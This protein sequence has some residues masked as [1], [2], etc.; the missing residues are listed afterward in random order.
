MR[1]TSR[2]IVIKDDQLLV[3]ERNKFGHKYIALIGGGVDPGET[4]EQCLVRE[5]R[6]EATI[7]IKN[8]RLVIIENAGNVYGTQY[9][10][11]CDWIS[12]EP[13][14]SPDS[15]EAIISKAGQNLY[16]P[17]WL[18]LSDLESSVFMPN[19][20][21]LLLIEMVTS[22]FPDVPVKLTINS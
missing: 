5:L 4:L 16:S 17:K 2:A 3:M 21:K 20:L 12:A 14:L 8:P 15:E 1:T 11:L 7:E 6:E 9:I 18:P 10:Y 19:E 13:K 22:G